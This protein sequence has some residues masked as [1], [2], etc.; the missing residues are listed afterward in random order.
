M[1]A[2]L[3][4]ATVLRVAVVLPV[5][6][7][8][9]AMVLRARRLLEVMALPVLRLPAEVDRLLEVT[10]HPVPLPEVTV[11]PVHLPG[12]TVHPQAD[13][14]ATG[15]PVVVA[16]VHP[17]AVHHL[18]VASH[19]RRSSRVLHRPAAARVSKRARRSPSLGLR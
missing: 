13:R 5:L 15:L 18:V 7:L 19:L 17:L 2:I 12:V 4:E 1:A 3:L 10:V 16:M 14:L 8:L 9:E 6:R 11:R